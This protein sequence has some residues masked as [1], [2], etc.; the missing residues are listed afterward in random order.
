VVRVTEWTNVVRV[1]EWT[2]VVRVTEWTNVVRV[3]EWTNVVRVKVKDNEWVEFITELFTI[4][5]IHFKGNII[6]VALYYS[7][8]FEQ[9]TMFKG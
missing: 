9:W 4:I 3:M 2:N 7:P 1:T 8:Q 5:F 6:H